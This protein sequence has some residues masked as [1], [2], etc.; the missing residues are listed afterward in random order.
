M[1]PWIRNDTGRAPW[2]RG[3]CYLAVFEYHLG[4]KDPPTN[5]KRQRWMLVIPL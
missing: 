1:K 2:G 3:R 5:P 4:M